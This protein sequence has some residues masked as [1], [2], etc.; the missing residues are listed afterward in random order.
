M[1]NFH[2][3]TLLTMTKMEQLPSLKVLSVPNIQPLHIEAQEIYTLLSELH[4]HA[5]S[6]W[7]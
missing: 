5:Q 2:L 6:L 4:P 3:Y 7:P 1:I